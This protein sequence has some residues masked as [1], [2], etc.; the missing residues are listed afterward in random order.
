MASQP[1]DLEEERRRKAEQYAAEFGRRARL[2]VY[3]ASAPGAGKTRRLLDDARRMQAAGKR[4][5]IG[6]LDT[7]DRP[8]LEKLAEGIERV[9]P[10]FAEIEGER[11]ADFDLEAA[12]ALHP[13]AI[14][15]DE[16][17]HDN[18]PGSANAKRWQDALTLRQRGIS[19]LGA[20][21]ITH[22]ETAAPV[23]QAVLG[24][25]VR[26]IV[27]VS[28]LKAADEVIALDVSPSL[29]K[30]R[31]R[32]GKVVRPEDVDR[33]LDAAFSDRALY[34]LRELL[35]RTIDELT[36][37][38]VSA[39]SVSTAAALVL[40][41]VHIEPFLRRTAAVAYALDLAVQVYCAP[42]VSADDVETVAHQLDAEVLVGDFDERRF[43]LSELRASLLAVPM[44]PLARRLANRP[45][46]RDVFIVGSGQTFLSAGPLAEE[47]AARLFGDRMRSGYGKLTVFLGP[48]AGSGKTMAMLDRGHQLMSEGLDVVAGFIETHGRKETAALVHGLEVLPRKTVTASGLRYEELDCDAVIARKPQVV[49]IDEL[50][51]TNAP[52]FSAHKRYEDV[53]A[54]L[55]AGIDVITTLNVQHLEGLTD[56][57]LRLTGTEVRET[58]PDEILMLADEVV[59]IDVTPETLR[60]RLREGKIY[61]PERVDTALANF[62]TVNNIKALRELAVREAI[63][64]KDRER[65]RAPFERLLL[66]V[67]PRTGDAAFIE[68]CGKIARRLVTQFAV[69]CLTDEKEPADDEIVQS[70]EQQARR[71]GGEWICRP[72]ADKPRTVLEIART[73]AETTVA[74]GGATR[75]P[76]WLERGPFAKRLIDAGARELLILAQRNQEPD[77]T[78][79]R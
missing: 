67:A 63:S 77:S 58:L 76:R 30:S 19:V 51:H 53:L 20:F 1:R 52:G 35:L 16:L 29:L 17:A 46:D 75:N 36:I 12:L 56:A 59:L 61:S 13:D 73:R 54:I 38:A 9:P 55:R 33:A 5:S 70:L 6:W 62:F 23:A 66:S 40:P 39:G 28:F 78:P 45:V 50:A 69:L 47:R 72:A 24:Y 10:R 71:Y 31:L 64:A 2:L 74:V 48:A 26:E 79:E 8:D 15:L 57:V 65:V 18:L 4:V 7:K 34:V 14:V 25:P 60:E 42:S 43:D 44:S 49:L 37:P 21:N 68:R 41:S 32:S 11:F 3:I 27:P 22:L